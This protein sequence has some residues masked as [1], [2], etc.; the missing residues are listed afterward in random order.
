MRALLKIVEGNVPETLKDKRVVTL[1]LSS[2]VVVPSISEFE[3][4]L[5]IN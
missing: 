1:D 4:A 2:M 3:I 5:K